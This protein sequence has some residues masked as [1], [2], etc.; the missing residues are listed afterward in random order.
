MS[1]SNLFDD[2]D[3]GRW[4]VVCVCEREREGERERKRERR[5][6]VCVRERERERER[7][8]GVKKRERK[9]IG[10]EKL[11]INKERERK[12]GRE[13]EGERVTK[14]TVC[15]KIIRQGIKGCVRVHVC[16]DHKSLYVHIDHNN[17]LA[18]I[19]T[20]SPLVD[21]L[22]MNISLSHGDSF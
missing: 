5:G 7:G 12:R 9:E 19:H 11:E 1:A 14:H 16:F 22:I 18:Q 13:I 8:G 4:N 20:C 3:G 21:C 6:G 15:I 10:R 2:I 17:T